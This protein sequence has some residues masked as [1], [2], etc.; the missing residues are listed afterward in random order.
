MGEEASAAVN[1]M[2]DFLREVGEAVEVEEEEDV[3]VVV[4][5]KA[6]EDI[7]TDTSQEGRR[8]GV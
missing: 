7:M 5:V 8:G 3:G 6:E 1:G 4:G 2:E